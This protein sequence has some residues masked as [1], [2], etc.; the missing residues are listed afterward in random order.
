MTELTPKKE[1]RRGYFRIFGEV[2]SYVRKCK[3]QA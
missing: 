3:H 2:Q 1:G